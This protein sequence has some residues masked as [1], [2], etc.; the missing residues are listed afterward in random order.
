MSFRVKNHLRIVTFVVALMALIGIAVA[1]GQLSDLGARRQTAHQMTA[2]VD[3]VMTR[4]DVTRVYCRAVGRPHTSQR[5]DSVYIT[6]PD[7]SSAGADDID[8]IYF[9]RGFQWED[10]TDLAIELDFPPMPV[11]P[12]RFRLTMITPY[13]N[14]EAIYTGRKE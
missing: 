3:S 14:V 2:I 10:E 7:G 12:E 11:K 8:P 1:G 13:G 5:I 6:M 9:R 4:S